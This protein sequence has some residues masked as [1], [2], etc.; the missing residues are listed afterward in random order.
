MAKKAQKKQKINKNQEA[1]TKLENASALLNIK[2]NNVEGCIG[3]IFDALAIG[4][5]HWKKQL[6]GIALVGQ[7]P[8]SV[9]NLVCEAPTGGVIID[10]IKGP[11][12]QNTQKSKRGGKKGGRKAKQDKAAL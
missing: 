12:L 1:L 8:T 6:Q 4:Q 11:V 7:M 2:M 3:Y 9:G 10:Q 5:D